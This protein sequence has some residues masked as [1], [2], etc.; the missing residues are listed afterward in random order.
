MNDH[1]LNDPSLKSLEA[2]LAATPPQL[3]ERDRQSLLYECAFA[4][5]RRAAAVQIRH[6]QGASASL[7]ALLVGMS[8]TLGAMRLSG[9]AAMPTGANH[10]APEHDKRG[11]EASRLMASAPP[12]HSPPTGARDGSPYTSNPMSDP[13]ENIMTTFESRLRVE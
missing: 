7:A 6:W 2:R 13:I 12:A 8:L 1:L 9:P 10:T 3:S 5:G 4:A 11:S